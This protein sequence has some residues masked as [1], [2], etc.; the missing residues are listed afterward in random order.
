MAKVKD[1]HNFFNSRKEADTPALVASATDDV[2]QS[3][4]L[5][6]ENETKKLTQVKKNRIT[7]VPENIKTEVGTYALIHR[8]KAAL[9]RFNKIHPK[10]IFLRIS[11]NS[12]K[13]KIKKNKEG[14]TIF[15]WKGRSNLFSD[16][17]MARV[18]IVM[19]ETRAAGTAISRRIIMTIGNGV[20]KSNNPILLKENGGSLQLTEDWAKGVLK[21]M[22]WG[23]RKG[24]TGK[25]KS[26][27][28]FLLEEKLTFQ[29][30]ISDAIFYHDIPKEL[31]V[32]LDQKPLSY[33]SPGKYTFDVK[34]IK[35]VP[36]KGI[37]YKRQITATIA[38]S[39]SGEFLPIQL[40][41]EGKK[42]RCLPKY[43]FPS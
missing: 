33:V 24:T 10:Y 22:N 35:T 38:I 21:S 13:F 7:N 14:K 41:Y 30:K 4:L 3:E 6:V 26:S 8:T 12:C 36:I 31:I 18:K 23:K 15:K 2:S 28:Q 25:I 11:I 37:N 34:G 19:T 5:I 43:A 1:I 40:I 9:E 29:K 32:N 42:T 27:R 20:V 39:S 17:L 16:N